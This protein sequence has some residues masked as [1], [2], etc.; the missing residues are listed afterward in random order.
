MNVLVINCCPVKNGATAEIVDYISR[1]AEKENIVKTVCVDAMIYTFAKD[2][3]I[4]TKQQAVFRAM[5]QQN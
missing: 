4:V 5:I 1:Y 3:A 2:A